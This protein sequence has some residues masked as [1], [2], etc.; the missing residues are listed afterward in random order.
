MQKALWTLECV[1]NLKTHYHNKMEGGHKWLYWRNQIRWEVKTTYVIGYG[2]FTQLAT[3]GRK[4]KTPL[5]IINRC[6]RQCLLWVT[7]STVAH[8]RGFLG[9]DYPSNWE[10][11]VRLHVHYYYWYYCY[12]LLLYTIAIYTMLTMQ[13]WPLLKTQSIKI[14]LKGLARKGTELI[15]LIFSCRKDYSIF[16]ISDDTW[17]IKHKGDF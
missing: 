2:C 15:N 6:D 11:I 16:L 4:L 13:L 8:L 1:Q 9:Q 12:T 5:N 7:V 14:T 10:L 17:R 3:L